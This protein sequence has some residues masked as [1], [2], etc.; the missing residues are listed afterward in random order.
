MKTW[1]SG[2][3]L[4]AALALSQ[5][6]VPLPA[7]TR[8][9][10]VLYDGTYG[11]EIKFLP[12]HVIVEMPLNH[13]GLVTRYWD[14]RAGMPPADQMKDVRGILTWFHADAMAD[15]ITFLRWCE[16]QI[17][18][19]K[20]MVVIGDL[21][22]TRDFKNRL[23]PLAAMNRLWAKIG[24]YSSDNWTGITYD[25]KVV[26][27]DSSMVEF[28]RALPQTLP[29]FIRMRRFD[30]SVKSYLT[31]RQ[32]NDSETDTDLVVIGK[33]GGHVA[34]NFMH[35][36]DSKEHNRL[37]YLN[38]FEYFRIAFATDDLPKPDTTTLVGR[39]VFYSHIDGDGWRNATEVLPY[40]KERRLSPHVIMKEIVEA[41]PDFPISIAP[42]AADLDPEWHGT[43]E[44]IQI[45]RD[46]FAHR[47][48]EAGS[49]TYA[50]PLE[51]GAF[52]KKPKTQ[53]RI[54]QSKQNSTLISK[55]FALGREPEPDT[56]FQATA[57][58]SQ[59]ISYTDQ[60]FNLDREIRGAAE[61]ISKLLPPGKR[62]QLLQWSGDAIP[63]ESAIEAT[64]KAGLRNINGGDTRMDPEYPSYGWVSPVGLQSGNQR[65]IYASDSNENTYTELWTARFFGFQF[66]T[67][68]LKNTDT[69]IRLKP[70]NIYFHMYSGEKLPS[71]VAII[72]NFKYARAQ[73]LAP[74][75]TSRFAAL[76][77]GF[78]STKLVS[79]GPSTWRVE[80]RDGLQTIRFD[81][82]T[83]Q[84]VDF[85][86]SSGVLGQRRF[87]GSLYV[88][89]DP[90]EA[91]PVVA[92][93][94]ARSIEDAAAANASY[95]VDSRWE[96]SDLKRSAAGFGFDTWGYGT[97]ESN[98]RV[99]VVGNYSVRIR[100]VNGT[101]TDFIAEVKSDQ[102]LRLKL[103]ADGI[104]KV[105]VDVMRVRSTAR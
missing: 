90:A 75:P 37:W 10:L 94:Q 47:N 32:G 66:L 86:R 25:W 17:D 16:T 103:G 3:L 30:S 88:A 4:I 29:T 50:H 96:V 8:T 26:T 63:F 24:L 57:K 67:R 34:G 55:L 2:L 9:I 40:R 38:P 61:F 64:R 70:H 85:E 42:I 19:G 98:W 82:S 41:F 87:Q 44:S 79:L 53:P 5:T 28:E 80:G 65:Q 27:R 73:E 35:Y 69:P 6:N 36:S 95:L 14:I 52:S 81:R 77:D 101:A 48:V 15:P 93:R 20:K 60:P 56:K 100:K 46:I 72:E 71:L 62:V 1:C 78:Y 68:T 76:A 97:G 7:V 39:R 23:T 13:L 92:L 102:M 33:N 58:Y 43:A 84:S 11:D 74:I 21:A 49:H 59:P 54:S 22:V 31:V 18:A 104:D 99:P 12:V 105:H 91:S 45:A 51:W 89:L 83:L